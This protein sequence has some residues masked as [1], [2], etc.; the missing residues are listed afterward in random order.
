MISSFFIVCIPRKRKRIKAPSPRSR[1]WPSTRPS[2]RTCTCNSSEPQR[3]RRSSSLQWC[4]RILDT[5]AS[6]PCDMFV[7]GWRRA[8]CQAPRSQETWWRASPPLRSYTPPQ[9]SAWRDSSPRDE[10]E[11]TAL[12]MGVLLKAGPPPLDLSFWSFLTFLHHGIEEV[13][14][15]LLWKFYKKNSKEKLVKCATEVGRLHRVSIQSCTQ[16]RPSP[17]VQSLSRDLI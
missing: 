12:P 5:C 15:Q 11:P 4:S 14:R 2:T 6:A 16:N 8:S 7:R 3:D 17:K 9:T 1:Y 10:I 13:E